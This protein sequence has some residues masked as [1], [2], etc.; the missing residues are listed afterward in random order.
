M[1]QAL[2]S[3]R[4]GML[5]ALLLLL[6]A[7]A[8]ADVLRGHLTGLVDRNEEVD[9]RVR[10]FDTASTDTLRVEQRFASVTLRDGHFSVELENVD[11]PSSARFVEIALRPSARPY[12]AFRPAAPRRRLQRW[13]GDVLVTRVTSHGP[14]A[15]LARPTSERTPEPT[16]PPGDAR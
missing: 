1:K 14:T 2:S 13:N 11:I 4:V 6:S 15:P 10:F 12:A 7:S 8:H 5:M 3:A 9:L 16:H